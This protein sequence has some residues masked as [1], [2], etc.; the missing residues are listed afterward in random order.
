MT[1]VGD[2][3]AGRYV[4]QVLLREVGAA[5]Q[6]RVAAA[7]VVVTGQGVAAR[8]CALYL[9]G[10]GVGRLT[11]SG[12]LI[13]DVRSLNPEVDVRAARGRARSFDAYIGAEQTA[14]AVPRTGRPVD[15]GAAVALA[16]LKR[17]LQDARS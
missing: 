4:R 16:A 13:D 6:A 8:V 5:G 2:P 17:L 15:D 9:A 3:S 1:E 12:P 7:H 14:V 11:V 10:A